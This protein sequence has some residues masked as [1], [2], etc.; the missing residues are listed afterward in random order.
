MKQII[1]SYKYDRILFS[2]GRSFNKYGDSIVHKTFNIPELRYILIV[3]DGEI[4]IYT[5]KR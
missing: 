4:R 3:L 2:L 1:R 5:Y